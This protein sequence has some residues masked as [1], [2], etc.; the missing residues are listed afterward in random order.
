MCVTYEQ[1]DS[2]CV[3]GWS[4][5]NWSKENPREGSSLFALALQASFLEVNV[6]D[7]PCS[8]CDNTAVME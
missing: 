2:S 1:L 5:S 8:T 6:D 3:L 4:D 7:E